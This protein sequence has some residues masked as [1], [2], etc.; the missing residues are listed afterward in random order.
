MI[1]RPEDRR[2]STFGP[3]G[4][5]LL[6]ELRR[7]RVVPDR[8]LDDKPRAPP[9]ERIHREDE[10]AAIFIPRRGS[11]GPDHRKATGAARAMLERLDV[12]EGPSDNRVSRPRPEMPA[13]AGVRPG[14]SILRFDANAAR[15]RTERTGERAR[16]E[17]I[18]NIHDLRIGDPRPSPRSAERGLQ[19]SPPGDPAARPHRQEAP[20][21]KTQA[22]KATAGRAVRVGLER[23]GTGYGW[24]ADQ[25]GGPNA[26]DADGADLA[27]YLRRGFA[28]ELKT[29]LR[30]L[31]L[32]VGLVGGWAV[33]V[34]LSAAVTVPGT[35]VVESKVKKI[36]YPAGGVIAEIRA[37]DGM[38]VK[39]GDL[40]VRLDE[41]Q[42][43]ASLQ[44]IVD[45]LDETRV[46][47]TRLTAERDGLDEP[48]LPP[49]LAAQAGKQDV[50]RL[51]ASETSLFK[52]RLSARE[53]QK[54]LLHGNVAQ[55]E[56]EIGGL[57]AQ[58]KSK[59]AQLELISS[60]LQGVQTLFD[61]QLVPLTR[62]TGLQRQAAQLDGE[63]S[64]LKSTIAETRSRIGQAE[65]Q[66]VK[67][68]QDLRS[69]V[70]KDLR[71]SQDKETE[72]TQKLVAARDQL[73]RVEIRAPSAGVVHQL[74]VHTIGG[75]IAPGEVMMEIVPDSD[76][77]QIEARLPPVDIDQVNLGQD[78]LVRF[79]AF[80][81]RTTPQ[82]KGLVS[83]VSADLTEDPQS[84]TSYYTVRVQLTGDELRR[85]G[86]LQLVSGMPAELFLQTGSRTMMSYLLK[87]LTDQLKRTFSE[88]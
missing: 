74:T 49:D 12:D 31:V 88:R 11:A 62:L 38:R 33:V 18:S 85:L 73:N 81:Q 76:E 10:S 67:I 27:G 17:S 64:Q 45:Q 53:S 52:A 79:S 54:Q 55:L 34:P 43:R 37:Q 29:G 70:M 87:P 1:A 23:L 65:L 25:L 47:I 35:L 24:L 66:I 36:Q 2:L 84:K 63:R 59:S 72:L 30:V 58:I 9:P 50:A 61:K 7:I 82:I 77:L 16:N 69:E 75:V 22:R 57:D 78:V 13:H 71:E 14:P 20:A 68:D 51:F 5:A 4:A 32:G 19:R 86:N 83:Y 46:R 3:Q 8:D 26:A 42:L 44:V 15:R 39:E 56:E 60:E 40:L 28:Q 21:P 41:T 80:N 6:G 48:K